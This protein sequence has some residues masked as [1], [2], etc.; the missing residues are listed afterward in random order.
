MSSERSRM[1]TYQNG[2]SHILDNLI[3][4][5]L[6]LTAAQSRIE[7][8]DMAQE[9]MAVMKEDVTIQV[10]NALLAEA[11]MNPQ[12]ILELLDTTLQG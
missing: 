5:D 7:D 10:A 3:G 12:R 9:T 11:N 6:N 2:L 4:Y 8:A 1:G